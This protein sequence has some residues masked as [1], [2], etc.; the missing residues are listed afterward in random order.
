MREAKASP[1]PG[2][3]LFRVI[4]QSGA[5]WLLGFVKTATQL[6]NSSGSDCF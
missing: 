6:P 4:Q 3:V 2:G 1:Y 5:H